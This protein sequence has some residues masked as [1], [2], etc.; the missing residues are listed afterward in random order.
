MKKR[1]TIFAFILALLISSQPNLVMAAGAQAADVQVVDLKD[2]LLD[3]EGWSILN[4]G[5][6]SF[7]DG[8]LI[9]KAQ[10]D[11]AGNGIVELFGYTKEKYTDAIY[12]FDAEFEFDTIYNWSGFLIRSTNPLNVPWSGNLNYL[13]VITEEQIELQRFG[14]KHTF[15][16]VS[17][18]PFKDGERVNIR[19]GAIN[20][21]KGVHII[22]AINGQT[23]FDVYDTDDMFAITGAGHF[24]VYNASGVA[25]YPSSRVGQKDSPGVN[26]TSISTNG[27]VGDTINVDYNYSDI[28]G[29]T[30]GE[31]EFAWYRTLANIDHYGIS[32]AFSD[33]AKEKYL[34]KIEGATGRTYTITNNDVG[35][36]IKCGIKPKSKET[37]HLG[38][39]VFTNSVYVDSVSNMIG[40]G[41]FFAKD[42]PFAVLNGEKMELNENEIPFAK[43][44]KL[45]VPAEFSAK[46]YGYKASYNEENIVFSKDGKD[47]IADGMDV[48]NKNGTVFVSL[49]KISEISGVASTYEAIHEIGMVNNVCAQFNPLK[50]AEVLRNIRSEIVE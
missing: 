39:E 48:I 47:V 21:E 1:L 36:N 19:Y 12:D 42:S 34:E 46:A 26:T 5:N 38:E 44:G 7:K 14:V 2:M 35:F 11:E 28:Y 43:Y 33:E 10:F 16:A 3:T 9:N 27:I 50:Y 23:I 45:Y 32:A 29:T 40:N 30:E 6:T 20:E 17:P 24:G 37:G 15:L 31:T 41:L 18:T 13:I 4:E 8:A 49:N 22:L 25:L